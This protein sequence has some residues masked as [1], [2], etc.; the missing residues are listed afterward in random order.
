MMAFLG[1][2]MRMVDPA[3]A[4]AK[5]HTETPILQGCEVCE[6]CFKGIRDMILF[7]NKR[8]ISID[9]QGWTGSKKSYKSVPWTSVML[10][11]VQS[12]GSFMD[13]DSEMMIWTDIDHDYGQPKM[14][15][16]ASAAVGALEIA[17]ALAGADDND[18][19][20]DVPIPGMSYLEFD[21]QK[22]K[23]D[24]MAIQVRALKSI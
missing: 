16:G 8:L 5:F 10:F 13:K 24:L 1:G 15:A 22:D 9:V 7:T 4:N 12:A 21:F 3:Q 11:G 6:F 19:P 20:E 17:A 2:D 23:V 18:E 14:G